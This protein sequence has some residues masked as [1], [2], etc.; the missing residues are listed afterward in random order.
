[1]RIPLI[2]AFSFMVGLPIAFL[3]AQPAENKPS[4]YKGVC[5]KAPRDPFD[6]NPFGPV[7][8]LGANAVAV[9]PYAFCEP[10]DPRVRYDY[11][12]QWWG[13]SIQGV[14]QTITYAHQ[15]SLKINL[16]P[17]LWVGGEG[18]PGA[19]AFSREKARQAWQESYRSYI[20]QMAK[21]AGKY[22]VA[23]FTMGT[24]CKKLVQR[25][26]GYW[27]DLIRD[28]RAVYDGKVTY[29][30][31]WDNVTKVA[32]WD[33]LDYISVSGYFPLKVDKPANPK[34]VRAAWQPHLKQ[35]KRVHLAYGKP[36]LFG[37]YGYC[38]KEGALAK[39]WKGPRTAPAPVNLALQQLAYKSLYQAV[40]PKA[41]FK[42]GFLWKW[43][44]RHQQAGGKQD[45]SFTPQR[46]P[47]EQLIKSYYE[48][49]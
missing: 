35:L 36:V 9:V 33:Q 13:E 12:Q 26:P 18:W 47:A 30:A 1:M 17:H 46:K 37:E 3:N 39:P 6:G 44:P 34:A 27:R 32:F 28:V 22:D 19:L 7:K 21:I 4:T 48:T 31:N 43:H 16:K 14:R 41:W 29:Q 8:R 45:A 2:L 11:Q 15:K 40:W 25:F 5:L 24:E 20:M 42:G 23:L 38:S 10:D 49:F